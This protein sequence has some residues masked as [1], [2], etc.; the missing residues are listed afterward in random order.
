MGEDHRQAMSGMIS[1]SS[2]RFSYE[3]PE[4]RVTRSSGASREVHPLTQVRELG[5]TPSATLAA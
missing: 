1:P 3:L 4:P 5:F 2:I